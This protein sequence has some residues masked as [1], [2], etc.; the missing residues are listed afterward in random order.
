M[1]RIWLLLLLALVFV[2]M[3]ACTHTVLDESWFGPSVGASNACPPQMGTGYR[4]GSVEFVPIG[5]MEW[6]DLK[7]IKHQ[8]DVYIRWDL[9]EKKIRKDGAK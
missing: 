7:G 6:T 3:Q 8:D 2:S 9:N 1:K 4:V 5:K